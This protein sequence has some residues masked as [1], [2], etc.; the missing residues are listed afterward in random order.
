MA[1]RFRKSK[2]LGPVRLNV[3]KK[4]AS[5]SLGVPGLR[6]SAGTRGVHRTI[7]IPG[8]G[9]SHTKK[10]DLGAGQDSP[11]VPAEP[12]TGQ[13]VLAGLGL[14][15]LA[16]G[17]GFILFDFTITGAVVSLVSCFVFYLSSDA[18]QKV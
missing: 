7:G 4:S 9:L 13:K 18:P 15:C 10:V 2:S 1:F 17:V 6:V 3:G 5:V 14:L 11:P 12:L 8:T 16:L